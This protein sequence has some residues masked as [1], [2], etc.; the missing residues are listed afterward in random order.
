MNEV[1]MATAEAGRSELIAQGWGLLERRRYDHATRVIGEALRRFPG[2]EDVL[3]LAANLDWLQ[4]RLEPARETLQELLRTNPE[5]YGGRALLAKVLRESKDYAGAE[6]LWI[7]LLREEPEAADWYAEYAHVMLDT[8]H[9][10]KAR[11]LAAEGLRHD[12]ENPGCLFVHALTDVIESPSGRSDSLVTLVREHPDQARTAVALVVSLSAQRRN[13]EALRVAQE[14]LR[15]D[16]GR[17][18]LVELVRELKA[19]TH[20]ALLPLYPMQRWG[21]GGAI[22][23]WVLGAT[24]LLPLSRAY[25][26]PTGATIVIWT[27]LAYVVYSWVG[28]ALVRKMV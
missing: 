22:A 15:A 4:D 19:L 28:P 13:R 9:V 3:L 24:V 18:D 27:W 11:A 8:L 23:V 25:L 20:W 12:P 6:R 7:D 10:A 14:L 1:G 17:A 21:W 26:P 2:D 16:P 5:S